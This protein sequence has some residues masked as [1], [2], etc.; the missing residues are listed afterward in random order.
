MLSASDRPDRY[1]EGRR[2]LGLQQAIAPR[3]ENSQSAA[4]RI[5]AVQDYVIRTIDGPQWIFL[6]LWARTDRKAAARMHA[7]DECRK[8]RFRS[9]FREAGFD[10]AEAN[11][12]PDAYFALVMS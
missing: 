3:L 8:T 6:R 4:E 9:M 7:E 12:R 10:E 11:H 5:W 2:R 1:R